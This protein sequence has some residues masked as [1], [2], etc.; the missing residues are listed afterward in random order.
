MYSIFHGPGSL[1]DENMLTGIIFEFSYD[2]FNSSI[3]FFLLLNW[4][5]EPLSIQQWGYSSDEKSDSSFAF[6]MNFTLS[7]CFAL[8]FWKECFCL[9]V[10]VTMLEIWKKL[11][12]YLNFA[13]YNIL[14]FFN[15]Q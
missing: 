4:V 11:Q 5:T 8:Q 13:D 1:W 9:R 7:L 15:R 12:M 6:F 2:F 14:F 3:T 10:S